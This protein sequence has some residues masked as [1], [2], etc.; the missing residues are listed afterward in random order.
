MNIGWVKDTLPFSFELYAMYN[1]T[2]FKIAD[3]S[4]P[5]TIV[6]ASTMLTRGSITALGV[7][8]TNPRAG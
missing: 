1:G 8:A 3:I 6:K 5:T 7:N 2:H 4:D